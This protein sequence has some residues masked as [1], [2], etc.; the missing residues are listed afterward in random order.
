M[1]LPQAISDVWFQSNGE[2]IVGNNFFMLGCCGYSI[3][4]KLL[5][6]SG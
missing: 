6:V 3:L 5:K 1:S 4:A 2:A